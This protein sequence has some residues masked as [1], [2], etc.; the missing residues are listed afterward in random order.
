[1]KRRILSVLMIIMVA[2]VFSAAPAS[3]AAKKVKLS[4]TKITL[5]VKGTKTLKITGTKKKVKWSA[6]KKL[7]TIK[8]KGKKKHTAVIRAKK[9]GTCWVI[10]KVGKKKYRC[11]VIIKKKKTD[12]G[13]GYAVGP[14]P[15]PPERKDVDP[16]P[17]STSSK[18]LT[19]NFKAN[20]V[21]SR[22]ADTTFIN[23]VNDTSV[24]LLQETMAKETRRNNLL[25]SPDSILTAMAMTELGAGGTTRTEME[26]AFGGIGAETY[27]QYLATLNKR[28]TADRGVYYHIADSI[29]FKTGEITMKPAFLQQN[30]DYHSAE[31][32]EAPFNA[33]TVQDINNW[34]H[35]HT[36]GMIPKILEDLDAEARFALINA[37]AFEG[38]WADP[39]GNPSQK[40]FTKENGDSKDV[41]M[42]TG[43]E[44]TYLKVNGGQGFVKPYEGGNLAFLGI[45][46]PK[47]TSVEDFVKGL[48][49]TD[50][51]N[52]YAA[53]KTDNVLVDIWVPEFKY[54][55]DTN[56]E[57]VMQAMGIRKA[58]TGEADFSAMTDY[59][60]C[61]DRIIHKTHIELDK[62]GTKAA[63]ATAV[64][65]KAGSAPP[66][67]PPEKFTVHLDRPFV[68]AIVDTKTGIP[69]FLGY[70]KEI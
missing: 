41:N 25:I 55:Y 50:L 43:F 28:L 39:F 42:L 63:A 32:Y 38:R 47:G 1:M 60:V 61:I 48:K 24:K 36:N 70:V 29:W 68:Y 59:P 49:G 64:V 52:A 56:L 15:D 51:T 14:V 45:L 54:D 12:E 11:K 46:P 58:F 57:D 3:A 13:E 40:A 37:I 17:I 7:V 10:A 33:G 67:A 21:T 16:L 8:T 5:K 44:H 30:V 26:T 2:F 9:A 22:A 66:G 69:L 19:E 62:E 65:G 20:T 23:A 53:R 34:V 18:S 27:S 31:V 4:K 6:T 35:N